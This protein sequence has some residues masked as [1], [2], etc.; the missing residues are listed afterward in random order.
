MSSNSQKTKQEVRTFEV[1]WET[2]YV[3]Q[4][5][6]RTVVVYNRET[7]NAVAEHKVP[8]HVDCRDWSWQ[9]TPEGQLELQWIERL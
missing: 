8:H 4:F 9:V 1:D 3:S 5:D 6:S 7:K 2:C